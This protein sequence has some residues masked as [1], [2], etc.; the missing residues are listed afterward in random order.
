MREQ[1]ILLFLKGV[2]LI[3]LSAVVVVLGILA[4]I[5]YPRFQRTIEA[6]RGREALVGLELISSAEQII[7]MQSGGYSPCNPPNDCNIELN[8][9]LRFDNWTYDVS[10]TAPPGPTFIATATRTSGSFP[11]TTITIDET[12]PPFGGTW[13]LLNLIQ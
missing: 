12:G 8:L 13:P 11:N 4:A 7:L 1:N 10:V 3:E 5:V 2:T 9:D 6:T